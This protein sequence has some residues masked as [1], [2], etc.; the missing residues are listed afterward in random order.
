[1][2]TLTN[3]ASV[4]GTLCISIHPLDFM[5][6]S[7]N[8]YNWT[9][10]MSWMN[11]GCY[12][13]G[14]VEMMESPIVVCGYLEGAEPFHPVGDDRTWS[15]KKWRELFIVDHDVLAG[16]KGYPYCSDTLEDAC[17]DFIAEIVKDC[18]G[19]TYG[20]TQI[21]KGGDYFGIGGTD[22]W[23]ETTLMY[24]DIDSNSEMNFKARATDQ[25]P[26]IPN[27]IK[28][29]E[30]PYGHT[31]HSICWG[32]EIQEERALTCFS[33]DDSAIYC[34]CCGEHL[35]EDEVYYDNAGNPYCEYCYND[36][37]T[38]CD[39]CGDVFPDEDTYPVRIYYRRGEELSWTS[40]CLCAD[41]VTEGLINGGIAKDKNG[42]YYFTP[43][44]CTTTYHRD[45][46]FYQI[47]EYF[48]YEEWKA[49]GGLY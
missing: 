27:N 28:S 24:N 43:E 30:I 33:C 13:A 9:S 25:N 18:F 15:N 16:I 36:N 26:L 1:M 34:S 17:M 10:C 42:N 22:C 4:E 7:D 35:Y 11:C 8:N 49:K 31:P 41:C 19:W 20:E 2:S 48:T 46:P 45:V 6:M 47:D 37:F 39:C 12:R 40:R 32:D 44:G 38:A 14:S 29:L 5:T 23:F 21:Y 3:S